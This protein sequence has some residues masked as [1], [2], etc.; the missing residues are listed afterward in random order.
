MLAEIFMLRLEAAARAAKKPPP[1]RGLSRSRCRPE[2]AVIE[3]RS[4]FVEQCQRRAD[5]LRRLAAIPGTPPEE[6][7][8]LIAIAERW[9]SLARTYH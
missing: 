3:R 9:L 1:A 7:A 4:S 2:A 6:K 8:D 5:E